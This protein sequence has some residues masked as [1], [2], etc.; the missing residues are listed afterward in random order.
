MTKS[1][2]SKKKKRLIKDFYIID[3]PV[4]IQVGV[5]IIKKKTKDENSFLII[6]N[7]GLNKIQFVKTQFIH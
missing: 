6:N 3:F 5:M 7:L 2:V 4:I 1:I